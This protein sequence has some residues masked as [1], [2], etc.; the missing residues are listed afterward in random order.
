[1]RIK[2]ICV[3]QLKK[4]QHEG[5]V[6]VDLTSSLIPIDDNVQLLTE[7]MNMAFTKDDRVVRTEFSAPSGVF[8]QQLQTFTANQ[9]EENFL[10]FSRSAM[11]RLEDLVRGR[12]GATGG[13]LVFINYVYRKENMVGVFLVRDAQR[14]IFNKDQANNTFKIDTRTVINTDK[15]AMAAR[16]KIDSWKAGNERYHHF[17]FK[18]TSHSDYFA[19]WVEAEL[20]ERSTEDTKLLLSLLKKISP[21]P[22]DPETGDEFE[23]DKFLKTVHEF[24]QSSGKTVRLSD[25]GRTFWSEPDILLDYIDENNIQ[26]NSEFQAAP[27]ILRRFINYEAKSGHLRL[28]FSHSD[29]GNKVRLG[30]NQSQ[31]IIDDQSIRDRIEAMIEEGLLDE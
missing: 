21:L 6:S 29:W 10:N 1:M 3:H 5:D 2:F 13:Y 27:A 22:T 20:L 12:V 24:I 14:V 7:Q 4:K 9:T 25:L 19:D 18:A 15:L 28:L 23:S 11:G 30:D 17:T 26:I 16:I 31:V 8:Q